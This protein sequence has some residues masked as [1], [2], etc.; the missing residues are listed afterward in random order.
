[1]SVQDD[2]LIEKLASRNNLDVSLV[3]NILNTVYTEEELRSMNLLTQLRVV[4][5][6]KGVKSPTNKSTDQIIKSI[7]AIQTGE[8]KPFFSFRGRKTKNKVSIIPSRTYEQQSAQDLIDKL[9]Q[10]PVY[11]PTTQKPAYSGV[12]ES[13]DYENISKKAKPIVQD[14]SSDNSQTNAIDY[15]DNANLTNPPTDSVESQADFIA[16]GML[17]ILPDGFGF[18]RPQINSNKED[19]LKCDIFVS[20]QQIKRFNLRQSDKIKCTARFFDK[21]RAPSAIFIH[22]INDQ[23]CDK[24]GKRK[25]FAE[26]VATYPTER[27]L[28]SEGAEQDDYL[29][30][31]D[32]V[33]PIGKGQRGLIVA[34]PKTGK[35]TLLKKIAQSVV[36]NYGDKIKVFILL[37][38][39]RPEEVTDIKDALPDVEVAYSTFDQTPFNHATIAETILN[40]SKRRV[41]QGQ[42]VL[43][44]MDSLTR[45][46]RS[47]NKTVEVSGRTMTGG[48]DVS[49]LEIPKAFFGSARRVLNGGSLTI[50]ATA[51]VETGSRMDDVIYEEFKGTGNMEIHLDREL[52]DMRIFPAIDLQKSGTRHEEKLL[53]PKELDGMTA[54]RRFLSNLPKREAT[55]QFME[56]LLAT[57][58]N[59][60]FFDNLKS[61]KSYLSPLKNVKK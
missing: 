31:I 44:L 29:R 27:I 3:E 60:E 16:T 46:A 48:L 61:K 7:L 53:T 26:C 40:N 42:D 17:E 59:D 2:K 30:I 45:L 38:A 18:L 51:L 10:I 5:R 9:P 22:E 55:V 1:M 34:P 49:A 14:S 4:G 54:V 47:Y 56:T 41:E 23:T 50:L 35:T 11:R 32:V 58:N 12:R 6:I 33:A 57:S 36:K 37:V 52:A 24:I 20:S 39:E 25:T 13:Y 43:I 19:E 28:L 15:T 21:T 8:E